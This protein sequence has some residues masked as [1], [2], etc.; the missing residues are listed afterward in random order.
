MAYFTY[1]VCKIYSNAYHETT[2]A[3][4]KEGIDD[5]FLGADIGPR[6]IHETK[7]ILENAKTIFWNGP[8]GVFELTPFQKGTFELTNYLADSDAMTIVGGGDS[9]CAAY[10]CKKWQK[11]T[12]ISTG[13]GATLEFIEGNNLPGI[14]ALK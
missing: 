2:I 5:G 12:H 14:E 13:G 4:I 11:L 8:C 6:T 3:S 7:E 10:M 1:R 9:A